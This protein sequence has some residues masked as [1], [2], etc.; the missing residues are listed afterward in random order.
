MIGSVAS[1]GDWSNLYISIKVSSQPLGALRG[2]V[3][4]FKTLGTGEIENNSLFRG[5]EVRQQATEVPAQQGYTKE[6][7]KMSFHLH[8]SHRKKNRLTHS[9]PY[10]LQLRL[11]KKTYSSNLRCFK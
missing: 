2:T 11:E 8:I 5:Q 7:V 4:P 1:P 10:L 9:L 3:V 6:I